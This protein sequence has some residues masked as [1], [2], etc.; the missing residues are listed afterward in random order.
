MNSEKNLQSTE[1]DAYNLNHSVA[2]P[3]LAP[4]HLRKAG[5]RNDTMNPV[6]QSQTLEPEPED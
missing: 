5:N 1:E 3:H 6:S 2:L 4:F